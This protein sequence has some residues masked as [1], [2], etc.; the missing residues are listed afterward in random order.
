MDISKYYRI[1]DTL[2]TGDVVQWK[3]YGFVSWLIRKFSKGNENH[4]SLIVEVGGY[5]GLTNRKFMLEA[6]G[7]GI[8]LTSLSKRITEHKGEAYVLQ[9]EDRFDN[10]RINVGNW[11]FLQVGI[12]YDYD[13]L[14]KQMSGKVLANADQYFCSEFAYLAYKN[15]DIPMYNPDDLAP[16]PCDME[17]L[18]IFKMPIQL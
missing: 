15:A 3:T 9:L 13:S 5:D 2:K 6:Q 12:K 4:T 17:D 18:G 16:R 8:V 7:H 10:K 14:F 11:A 1:R